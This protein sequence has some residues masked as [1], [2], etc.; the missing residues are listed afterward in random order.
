M[1]RRVVP[2]CLTANNS[3]SVGQ[4]KRLDIN[5]FVNLERLTYGD[6]PCAEIDDLQRL[7]MMLPVG[8]G[9]DL[10]VIRGERQVV[11]QI[12]AATQ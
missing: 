8:S 9:I 5:S 4:A 7:L 1:R 6:R 2:S 10:T 3:A 11:M 12:P